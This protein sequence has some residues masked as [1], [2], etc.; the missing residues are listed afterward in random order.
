MVAQAIPTNPIGA[1]GSV[2]HD[3]TRSQRNPTTAASGE[4]IDV[5]R[6]ALHAMTY[7]G[8]WLPLSLLLLSVASSLCP[9]CR[10]KGMPTAYIH[11]LIKNGI[12]SGTVE[13]KRRIDEVL[14]AARPTASC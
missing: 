8:L 9:L 13:L 14:N 12:V 6:A 7:V 2:E 4:P 1:W 5:L 10:L 3:V 11:W